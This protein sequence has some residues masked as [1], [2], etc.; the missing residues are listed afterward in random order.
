MQERS[1]P[2]LGESF[3]TYTLCLGTPVETGV[4][5]GTIVRRWHW[6]DRCLS[7]LFAHGHSVALHGSYAGDVLADRRVLAVLYRLHTEDRVGTTLFRGVTGV[8]LSSPACPSAALAAL[9]AS[10]HSSLSLWDHAL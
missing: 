1:L 7:V 9:D 5:A 2:A 8:L 6:Y 4:L 10:A 3:A